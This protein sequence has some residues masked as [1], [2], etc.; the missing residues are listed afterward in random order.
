MLGNAIEQ[1][2][3]FSKAGTK[4]TIKEGVTEGGEEGLTQFFLETQLYKLDP[5]RDVAA[6]VTAATSFG[7]LA[8]APIAG[9][10][11]SAANGSDILNAAF[12]I[13]N[14]QFTKQLQSGNYTMGE[15]STVLNNWLPNTAASQGIRNVLVPSIL[16][17]VPQYAAQ[18]SN[19]GDFISAVKSA[20]G[21]SDDAVLANMAER[22]D[23]GKFASQITSTDEA[24]QILG[25]QGLT[26]ASYNDAVKAGIVG[27][28]KSDQ[29]QLAQQYSNAQMVSEQELRAAASQENYE[30]T[31]TELEKLV[32]R[33]VQADVIAKF[34]AEVDPKA[35]TTAEATQYFLDQGYTKARA[36]DIAQFV[37][38]APED[39]MKTAV[40]EWVNPRQVT[41][42]EALQFFSQIGYTPS[43]A[44]ITQFVVQGPE[45]FQDAIKTQLGEYVDPRFVDAAE[46]REAFKTMGLNAPV[47]ASDIARLS[48][49]YSEAELA[50]K[51]E[52]ALPIV[53]ANAVYALMAGEPSIVQSVKEEILSKIEGY[54]NLGM[55]GDIANKA[56]I[57]AVAAQ[58]GTSSGNLLNAIG[59]TEQN[60]LVKISNT[61]ETL[62]SKI[63]EYKAQGLTQQAATQKALDEMSANLGTTK[64]DL[65]SK[66]GATEENLYTQISGV[67][68]E[69]LDKITLYQ[70]QGL[71]QQA[72]TQKALD[73][74]S[75]NLGTT[76]ESLLS[77][78]GATEANL[79]NKL[80]E[81][82]AQT[83]E[84]FV[85]IESN[86]AASKQSILNQMA[87]YE[88]AGMD[89]DTALDLAISGV[90][91]DLGT[92][93]ADL[94]GQMG[95]TEAN[96]KAE[97]AGAKSE[98]AGQI[99]EVQQQVGRPQQQ[100]TA[101]DV[102]TIQ[103]IIAGTTPVNLAYD[104][105]N[106]GKVDQADLTA[107][108]SQL[109]FQQNQN[110]Q[111]K[112]DSN[113]GLTYYI[114]TTTG[115]EVSP[116]SV[117]GGQWAPTGVYA[118]LMQQEARQAEVAKAQ[119]AQA[120]QAQQKN[121]FGQLM[122]MLFQAPDAA[123][124]QVTVK[125][126]DPSKIGYIYD[127]SSIFATPSQASLM[128]SPYGAM[129]T[130][131]PQQQKQQG[132]PLFSFGFA[133][134]GIVGGSDMEVGGSTNVD[135][136]INILKGNG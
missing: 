91:Q 78:I 25:A 50:G 44:E 12:T 102:T 28:T 77:Q 41:R 10:T 1:L 82:Q 71:T 4:I 128:P 85:G 75:A 58:L 29:T 22:V 30:L 18:Y 120:K 133:E 70:Q 118:A 35:V 42:A 79:M 33:G 27:V 80:G 61:E 39:S 47:A 106:D 2:W 83:E 88:Q 55:A 103:G 8:G 21:V 23:N 98:L 76:R 94:I 107:V 31:A 134:G 87:A 90:A 46:V 32:G 121:Q 38:S 6:S 113:T 119:A 104:T 124:Q 65:L 37:K 3:D 127:W 9:G 126:P 84:R 110:I 132:Q 130:V 112:V 101:D 122:N 60:L 131:A 114:D 16:E 19:A 109:T 34:I 99:G 111:Q 59:A 108:Q 7:F 13:G 135:D 100:A 89:R 67:R 45:V 69:L 86:I 15:L 20:T 96:L 74:M 105:N 57:D 123:G 54:Q 117:L 92:T 93:K 26:N 95:T 73:E 17:S 24:M 56:A 62:L 48:G 5:T 68:Q 97:L 136:L 66:I 51:A 36:E 63:N 40:A 14:E 43:E 11:F 115:Q 125:T 129:N 72:A 49:Q 52:E 53:S 81:Y 64:E 116:P